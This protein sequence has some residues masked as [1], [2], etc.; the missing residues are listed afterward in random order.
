MKMLFDSKRDTWDTFDAR[1][2]A[3]FTCIV[4]GPPR[5]G[6]THFVKKLLENRFR[7]ID[8]T[9]DKLYW[10]YG[11]YN[12]FIEY[13]ESEPFGIPT[14]LVH[15]LP[16]SFEEYLDPRE[17]RLI[18]IDDLMTSAGG[19]VAVTDLFCNKVQHANVSVIL[20]LQNV[21]YHGKERT[22][23]LRCAT[24]LV[25]FKNPMDKSVSNYLGMKLMP[26][27]RAL[28]YLIFN[29][30]TSSP[31]G[32]LFCDGSQTTPDEVRLRTDIFDDNVQ[33][34]FMLKRKGG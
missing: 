3:S 25:I 29:Q 33:R 31:H 24:Y 1:I 30:A 9:I 8:K 2:K 12:P 17:H 21:F 19:S 14:T 23:L 10:F 13:L 15:G 20:L 4:S 27:D 16:T 7:L 32:Y 18:V 26:H 22:T 34:A 11:E 5:S 6:K 28:F